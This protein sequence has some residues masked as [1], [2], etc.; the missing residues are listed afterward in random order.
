MGSS[1]SRV[2]TV[3][4]VKK[5]LEKKV[6]NEL[7]EIRRTKEREGDRLD[8]MQNRNEHAMNAVGKTHRAKITDLQ[9]GRAFLKELSRQIHDQQKKLQTIEKHEDVKRQELV[10]KSQEKRIVE[11]LEEKRHAEE[12]KEIEKKHQNLIDMLAQRIRKDI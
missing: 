7:G 11:K 3:L 12:L 9:A 8:E 6:Q 1:K 4:K 2:R 5:H 10:E